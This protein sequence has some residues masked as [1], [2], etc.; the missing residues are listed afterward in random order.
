MLRG[1]DV[2][3]DYGSLLISYELSIGTHKIKL[4]FLLLSSATVR[5]SIRKKY[6]FFFISLHQV[7]QCNIKRSLFIFNY[8]FCL[9]LFDQQAVFMPHFTLLTLK[10]Y[11]FNCLPCRVHFFVSQSKRGG[12]KKDSSGC[13]CFKCLIVC[14]A[15]IFPLIVSSVLIKWKCVFIT[16]ISSSRRLTSFNESS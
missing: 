6:W 10:F 5:T 14:H 8:F 9:F 13:A 15:L 7:D 12:K 4:L 2:S 1:S 16:L 11:L 3:A